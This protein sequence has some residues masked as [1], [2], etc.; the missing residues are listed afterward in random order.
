MAFLDLL[1]ECSDDAKLSDEDIREEVDTFMSEGH[2]TTAAAV[3]WA[4][5]LL[6]HHPEIQVVTVKETHCPLKLHL[7]YKLE[8]MAHCP[9]ISDSEY[10]DQK[11]NQKFLERA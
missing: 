11:L 3:N 1:L 8:D 4:L 2:A 9:E 5:F 10:C 6:G 7:E